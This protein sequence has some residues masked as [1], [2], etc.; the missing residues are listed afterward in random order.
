MIILEIIEHHLEGRV[1]MVLAYHQRPFLLTWSNFNP[2]MDDD[3]IRYKVWDKITYP[4]PNFND[5]T[6]E[7]W[8]WIS[9]SIPHFTGHVITYP[10]WD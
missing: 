2:S 10:C 8:E 9:N 5:Y 6:I 3:Y 4:I 1:G 7:V